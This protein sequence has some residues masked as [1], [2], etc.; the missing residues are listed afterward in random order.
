M[1]SPSSTRLAENLKRFARRCLL[2]CCNTPTGYL[3]PEAVRRVEVVGGKGRRAVTAKFRL[4]RWFPRR[5][6]R[7][8]APKQPANSIQFFCSRGDAPANTIIQPL[9]IAVRVAFA[10]MLVTLGGNGSRVV[11]F[12]A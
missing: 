12:F 11:A 10:R 4:C 1:L 7:E 5:V 2:T 3:E 8:P 9:A 6:S